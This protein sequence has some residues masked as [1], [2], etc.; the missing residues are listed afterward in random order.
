M[1]SIWAVATN[2]IKQ[3]LRMKVAAAFI[4]LMMVLLPA[5]S[6]LM[7]GD[8]TL[9]GRLQSFVSYGL[10]LTSLLLCLLTVIISVYSVTSD[11]TQ[12]QIYTVITKPI[13]R[14]QFLLG[15][16]LGVILLDIA[17]LVLFTGIIYAITVCIP[18]FLDKLL[19]LILLGEAC[20][21]LF[22]AIIYAMT[23]HARFLRKLLVV[24]LLG[25]VLFS[26]IFFMAYR[27]SNYK[28]DLTMITESELAEANNEFFTARRSLTPE[29]DDVSEEV[30]KTYEK[31]KKT[32]QLEEFFPGLS[33]KEIR[34]QLTVQEKLRKRAV[35]VGHQLVWEFDNVKPTD[36]N[37]RLFIRFK[38]DVTNNP[39][40]MKIY[41][42]WVVGDLRQIKYGI[43]IETP[44]FTSDRID[45]DLIRTFR[46]IEV[47]AQVVAKDGYLAVGFINVPLNDTI[48][49]F[50]LE[51]G[52]EVL[53]KADTFT[54]N[55][56]R[57]VLL[58][59]FRLIFLACLGILASTF[60]SFPVAIL[61][62]L[63]FFLIA[64]FGGF[65]VDTFSYLSEG[66]SM[67]YSYSVAL[68]IRLLPQ[69]D[70][71]NPNKYL[72]S[73]RFISWSV[74]GKAAG[75]MVCIKALLLLVAA[76]VIFSCREVAKI[77]V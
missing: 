60:L 76:L 8:G 64:S 26:V 74:V 48:V 73:G 34:K 32:N 46:E 10:S 14:S 16:L 29:E 40:D 22:G 42:R 38:Y 52:L 20:L 6:V 62:C 39:P 28:P 45:G 5:M 33:N 56:I 50:P 21:V 66:V 63:V 15:K 77:V 44:I 53:Y 1:R 55:Y 4:I 18:V 43:K 54:G 61:L 51:D 57:A 68:I 47:P 17:L 2:T 67:V 13:R 27:I 69:F 9:K 59:L 19:I 35:P 70:T 72:V 31:Y 36:P 3:A 65:W 41:G 58:L 71:F 30:E 23:I 49:I 12:R 7:T 75:L 24:I 11:I 37:E 25:F